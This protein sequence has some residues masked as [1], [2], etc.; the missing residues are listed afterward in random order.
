MLYVYHGSNITSTS[1]VDGKI[2]QRSDALRQF[3]LDLKVADDPWL[4][5]Y[6][7]ICRCVWVSYLFVVVPCTAA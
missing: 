7:H 5:V 3:G 4:V 2:G 6:M 1:P